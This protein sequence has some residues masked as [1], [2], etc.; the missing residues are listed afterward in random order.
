MV[1][2]MGPWVPYHL[3]GHW[4]DSMGVTPSAAVTRRLDQQLLGG[5]LQYHKISYT[6][7]TGTEVVELDG[8]RYYSSRVEATVDRQR[9]LV[10]T[11]LVLVAVLAYGTISYGL[12]R[13]RTSNATAGS[14][15]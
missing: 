1:L 7:S 14:Q 2:Y 13:R 5:T 11:T 3:E 8:T 10:Q 4:R 9:L 15:P 12:K 6:P